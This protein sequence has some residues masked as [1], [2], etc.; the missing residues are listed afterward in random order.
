MALAGVVLIQKSEININSTTFI[1]NM[2]SLVSGLCIAI[3]YMV[4]KTL[5][6]KMIQLPTVEVCFFS[7]L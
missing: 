6:K 1:G 3:V 7:Q 4:A 2:V 5:E